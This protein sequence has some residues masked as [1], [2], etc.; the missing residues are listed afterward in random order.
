MATGEKTFRDEEDIQFP[1]ITIAVSLD[2]LNEPF[3]VDLGSIPPFVAM[4]VLEK[5]INIL[6]ITVPAPKVTFK[7]IT[8]VEPSGPGN[9]NFEDFLQS[10][11]D[12]EEDETG[13]DETNP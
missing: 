6:K 12:G 10:F 2:D 1:V 13:D 3:H 4:S 8:L 5:V 7:G 9:M 11:I